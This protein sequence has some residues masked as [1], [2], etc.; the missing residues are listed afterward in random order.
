VFRND[1]FVCLDNG[2]E[3]VQAFVF[4]GPKSGLIA[5]GTDGV[6]GDSTQQTDKANIAVMWQPGYSKQVRTALRSLR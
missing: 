5:I 6:D 3:G 2:A 1:A 4:V